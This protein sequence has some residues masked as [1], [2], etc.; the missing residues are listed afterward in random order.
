MALVAAAL[1]FSGHHSFSQTSPAPE[2]VPFPGGLME[3]ATTG[4]VRPRLSAS[5]LQALLPARGPFVFP[6]PYNTQAVR[7]TNAS[8]CGGGDCVDAVGYSYWRNINN[9]AAGDDMLILLGLN[10][11][12][13][14][15]GP[16]LFRYNKLTDQVTNLGPLFDPGSGK[17][18]G[19]TEGWY[20][21]GTQPTKIYIDDGPR[22][23][24]YDVLTKQSTTVF[25]VAPRYGADKVIWQMHSSDD[26][27]VHSVTLRSTPSFEMLG[28]L[29]YHEDTAQ[30]QYFPKIG[31]FNECH[32]D[33]SGRWLMS[34]EDV[35]GL[36]DLEMRIFN[37]QDGTERLVMDQAGAVG[38]ADMGHGYMIGDDN[39]N[40]RANAM[41]VWDFAQDPL[42]G[43]LVSYNL[44]WSAPAPNHTSHGNARPGVPISDQYACGSSA[45]RVDAIWGNEI[46]CFRLDG[47]L[48]VL[49]V[50]P[51]M[52]DLNAPGGG[53]D[54]YVKRP[55]GNL[56]VTG[57]YF[58]WTSNAGGNRL[59]A[60]LVKVPGQRLLGGTDT[61]S[62]TATLTAPAAGTSVSGTLTVAASAAD[63][64]GVLGVQFRLDGANLGAEDT[65]AP[66]SISWNTTGASTGSHSL[67]AV[68]RD[69][70]GNTGASSPIGVTV[71]NDTAPPLIS[72]VLASGITST[73]ATITWTTGEPSDTQVDYG[74]TTAYGSS[75]AL[76]APLVV[77][78]T[79]PLSGLSPA[80]TY[81]YR[82]KS[83]DAAGNLA[84]SGDFTFLT[85]AAPP[86]PS[87]SAPILAISMSAA[88]SPVVAGSTLTYTLAY[89]NTG[90]A[91]ASGVVLSDTV[92]AN[93]TFVSAS[94]GGTLASGAVTWGLGA[95]SF[96]ASGSVQ[97]V[98]RVN[99]PLPSGTV[100]TN[101][102]YSID[103]NETSAVGGAPVATTV[104]NASAPTVSSVVEAM[105][106]SI[107]ILRPGVL[108]IRV[109]GTGFQRGATLALGSGIVSGPTTFIDAIHLEA[110]ITIGATAALGARSVTVTNPDQGS[111][112]RTGALMVTKSPDFNGNCRFDGKDLNTLARAWG[113]DSSDPTFNSQAD[114]NGD[115]LIDGNDLDILAAFFGQRLTACP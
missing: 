35:D 114:L 112:G 111:G 53:S 25:D 96:S 19:S 37:L 101:G 11:A 97:L 70:A 16:T 1:V 61:T 78:H 92:P 50:A 86:P 83:R 41:M 9:H 57:Q 52:T 55:K 18:Y 75:A 42:S 99:S 3:T 30:F 108:G 64:V 81:H 29:V 39:W 109:G 84:V 62:P 8:D 28:C 31:E 90:N 49:V 10:R 20:F 13:G 68:A 56:D 73:G 44:D 43:R 5:V 26:D 24:R 36:Y 46:I 80:V 98:V 102:S 67:T 54:D 51:V 77:A 93:T 91:N 95:L 15:A 82:V 27:R 87:G 105:T 6:A 110:T 88:P 47:S 38:H 32:V 34:L 106:G 89:A 66:Y 63:N 45:S 4:L 71:A 85:P 115:N 74:P 33:K 7:L 104:T 14:G 22:M 79:A 59:D 23:L 2:L 17:S 40:S 94:G 69:A 12:R 58:I 65:S 103:S 113:S 21:S 72:A 100:I 60:F 48:N 107:Y 76:S